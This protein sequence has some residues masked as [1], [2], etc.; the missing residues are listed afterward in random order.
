MSR[1]NKGGESDE[2]GRFKPGKRESEEAEVDGLDFSI[3]V[4]MELI[5]RW[6]DEVIYNFLQEFGVPN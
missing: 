6:M 4:M 1:A 3:D 2:T 5:S